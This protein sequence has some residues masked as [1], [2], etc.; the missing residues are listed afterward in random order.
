MREANTLVMKKKKLKR[1]K[2]FC[3][4]ETI[5]STGSV[6]LHFRS[7]VLYKLDLIAAQS[8]DVTIHRRS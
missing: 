1:Q 8:T 3:F 2:D 5:T 6:C 4:A 7:T